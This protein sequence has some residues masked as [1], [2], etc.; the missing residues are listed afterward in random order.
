MSRSVKEWK[1]AIELDHI[2]VNV[3]VLCLLYMLHLTTSLI[4]N[5][6]IKKKKNRFLLSKDIDL[7]AVYVNVMFMSS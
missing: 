5:K 2:K 7:S 4:K 1:L 3:T 6:Y